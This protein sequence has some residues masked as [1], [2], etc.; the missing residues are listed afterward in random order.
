M[1]FFSVRREDCLATNHQLVHRV[2]IEA[3]TLQCPFHT[4]HSPHIPYCNVY[5]FLTKAFSD[6]IWLAGRGGAVGRGGAAGLTVV[7]YFILQAAVVRTSG[8]SQ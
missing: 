3:H 4:L 8:L 6:E 5:Y 7:L 1:G 2:H